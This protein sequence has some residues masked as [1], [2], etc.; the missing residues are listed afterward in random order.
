MSQGSIGKSSFIAMSGT[1]EKLLHAKNIY[2]FESQNSIDKLVI[3]MIN[4]HLIGGILLEKLQN[5]FLRMLLFEWH[6][7]SLGKN[8]GLQTIKGVLYSV[9]V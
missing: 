5:I 2:K 7:L 6:C 3:P 9:Q 4:L 8:V 1:S